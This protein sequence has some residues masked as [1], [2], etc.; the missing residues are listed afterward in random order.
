MY[1][2]R[3]FGGVSIEGPNG[4]VAARRHPLALLAL[5][6]LSRS[7]RLSR[8]KLI[9]YL[10]PEREPSLARNLL[11]Q[12][13]HGLRRALGGEALRSEGDDL[14][15]NPNA[16]TCDVWLFEEALR[17]GD[18]VR[19][20][21][22]YVGPFVD[23]F[24]LADSVEFEQWTAGE[25][26]RL[27]RAHLKALEGL[28]EGAGARGDLGDAV[29]WWRRLAA[30]EPY[31]ANVILRFMQALESAGDRAG[32]IRQAE[33]HVEL[34]REEL[35]AAPSPAV[36]DLAE[37]MRRQPT[38]P[39]QAPRL[40]EPQPAPADRLPTATSF[41]STLLTGQTGVQPGLIRRKHLTLAGLAGLILLLAGLGLVLSRRSPSSSDEATTA[42]MA[43]AAPSVAVLPLANLSHEETQEYLATGM[44]AELI[45]TLNKLESLAAI[46]HRSVMRFKGSDQ[47][48]TEIA[49]ILGVTHLVDGSVLQVGDSV[50]ITVNLYAAASEVPMWGESF[51][52][53][54][55]DVLRLQRDV[56]LAMAEK[57]VV[58]LTSEDRGRLADAPEID[59]EAWNL[60]VRGKAALDRI[61]AESRRE[62]A[63]YFEQAVAE[64]S[65]YAP[66]Y[67]GLA[68]AHFFLAL[69]YTRARGFAEKALA[70]DP[71]LAE[72]HIV[73]GLIREFSEWDVAGAE[74]AF[75]QAIRVRP[76]NG[77][78]FMELGMLFMRRRQFDEALR[79]ARHALF[80][81]PL[82]A[83]FQIGL[84]Q[85]YFYN[86]KYDEALEAF[87]KTLEI[88]SSYVM[89]YFGLGRTFALQGRYAEAISA[90][91][92]FAKASPSWADALG[93]LGYAYA[94][95]GQ[96]EKASKLLGDLEE[97]WSQGETDV[98]VAR[99]LIHAGLGEK[100]ET[101]ALLER[102]N[103]LHLLEPEFRFLHG[104][105]RFQAL[106]AKVGLDR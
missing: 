7:R 78:A 71:N 12:S 19:A 92:T 90:S 52:G 58:A 69:D 61:T 77:E 1:L 39:A 49:R 31:N 70:L 87:T 68:S 64:D 59:P 97:R 37:R 43:R 102:V 55:R 96:R 82:S 3:L 29:E 16:V 45:T 30:Q 8:E 56:A 4:V 101:L 76:G 74:D 18:S 65:S 35:E 13:V 33:A 63:G 98:T 21:N 72:A 83:R 66:A 9:A 2:L 80:L 47:P 15:L 14:A 67:A 11:N 86:A 89:T 6:A 54:T 24:F 26:E 105:P 10:W 5:L 38:R 103:F 81:N 27:R 75:R 28:A 104:E 42:P 34:L 99:A 46:G 57:M 62:A 23:G 93:F 22:L 88:D 36:L 73:L 40:L 48:T 91:E 53:G 94:K 25:R 44:T 20:A 85:V 50:R 32:A 106:L 84:A 17:C 79:Y 60:L 100:E 51:T 41:A 95:S